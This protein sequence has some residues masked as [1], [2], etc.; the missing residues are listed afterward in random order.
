MKPLLVH[1]AHGD[2]ARRS[3]SRSLAGAR[4]AELWANIERYV[5]ET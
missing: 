4:D 5:R 3:I 1:L 2:K